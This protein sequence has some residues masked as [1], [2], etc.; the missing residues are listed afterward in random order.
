MIVYTLA[1]TKLAKASGYKS[2]ESALIYGIVKSLGLKT[3]KPSEK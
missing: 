2:K 1:R 3:A